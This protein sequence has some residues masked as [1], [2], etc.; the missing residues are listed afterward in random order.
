[1]GSSGTGTT[2][3]LTIEAVNKATGAQIVHVP[4]R[5]GGP[6]ISD[7]LA[8]TIDM[9]FDVMPALMPHVEAGRFKAFAVSSAQRLPF[10]PQVPGLAEFGA[11]GLGGLDIQTWS[12]IM[13]AGGTPE[14]VVARLFQAVKQVAAQPEFSEKLRPL[15]YTVRTSE[16]PA[17][18]AALIRDDTP[19]WQAL[20]RS[21][22]VTLD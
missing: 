13:T 15:G 10:L 4:Y 14:A 2:S 16:S 6:A 22:G 3:H 11:L 8:G 21:S 1:M 7:L 19:R 12:A 9:M 17:A 5:G 20:V 18:L